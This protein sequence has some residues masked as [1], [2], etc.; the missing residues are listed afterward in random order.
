MIYYYKELEI[1]M[2]SSR[3]SCDIKSVAGA[4]KYKYVIQMIP[5]GVVEGVVDM[6]EER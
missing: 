3:F 1:G 5:E 6:A 2:I 4:Y